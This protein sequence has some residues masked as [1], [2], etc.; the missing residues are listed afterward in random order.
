MK[1]FALR[2]D[3]CLEIFT[4]FVEKHPFKDIRP[5]KIIGVRYGIHGEVILNYKNPTEECKHICRNCLWQ[6]REKT[7]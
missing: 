6:L 2:C 3:L 5:E 4:E 7:K 1:E